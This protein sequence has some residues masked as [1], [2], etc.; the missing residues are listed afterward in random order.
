MCN[1]ASMHT[2]VLCKDT[3]VMPRSLLFPGWRGCLQSAVTM[4]SCVF[5]LK[6]L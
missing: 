6:G 1:C 5:V 4:A 3:L 2:H